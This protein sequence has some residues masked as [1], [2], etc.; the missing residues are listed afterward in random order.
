MSECGHEVFA[1]RF[2]NALLYKLKGKECGCEI[3][4][5]IIDV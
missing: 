5:Y 2:C 4:R 3:T 1:E